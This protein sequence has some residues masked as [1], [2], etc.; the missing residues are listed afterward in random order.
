MSTLTLSINA[1]IG[2]LLATIAEVE[3]K[4][5]SALQCQADFKIGKHGEVS[6]YQIMPDIWALYDPKDTADPTNPY[7]SK[8]IAEKI[9]WDRDLKFRL[10]RKR[11]PTPCEVYV[12]WNAPNQI[13]KGNASAKVLKR[14]L[15]FQ[16]LYYRNLSRESK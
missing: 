2:L 13:Y 10:N 3:T 7:T 6:R 12:L 9:L 5:T 14:A 11:P 8:Y 4:P 15:R 1:D 16:R